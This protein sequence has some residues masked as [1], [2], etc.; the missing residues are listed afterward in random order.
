MYIIM[1]IIMMMIT[2]VIKI[3]LIKAVITLNNPFQPDDF[4]TEPTTAFREIYVWY[5]EKKVYTLWLYYIAFSCN[6]L[7]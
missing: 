4:S 7:L 2:I 6:N 5:L 1:I 3:I